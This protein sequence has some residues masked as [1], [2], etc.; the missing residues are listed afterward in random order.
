MDFPAGEATLA[1]GVLSISA[2]F[3]VAVSGAAAAAVLT[4]AAAAAAAVPS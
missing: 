4:A 1:R 3:R 2:V